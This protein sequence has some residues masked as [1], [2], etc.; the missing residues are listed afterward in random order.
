MLLD[1]SNCN[2]R[3]LEDSDLILEKLIEQN[4]DYTS[5][6][7]LDASHN[8]IRSL[9]G[10]SCFENLKI[11][12]ISYNLLKSLDGDFIPSSTEKIIA[13]HNDLTDI[14]FKGVKKF[15]GGSEG[16]EVQ[17]DS[18]HGGKM[19]QEGKPKCGVQPTRVSYPEEKGEDSS[20]SSSYNDTYRNNVLNEKVFY[21]NKDLPLNRLAFLDVSFNK[22]KK[23]T[24]FERY[25]H[26]INKKNEQGNLEGGYSDEG[27][28]KDFI[29]NKTE[30]DVMLLFFN[31]LDT[32]Y[33][34]GNK[35]TNLKGLSV[36]KNLKVLDLRSNLINHPVQLFYLLDNENWLKQYNEKAMRTEDAFSSCS[37]P[38][39]SSS[40][41]G[42]YS[43]F[44]SVLQKYK[45]LKCVQNVFLR[46]NRRVLKPK[47]L[48]LSVCDVLRC[49]N[50][51]GRFTTDVS[52]EGENE[53]EQQGGG[54]NA[55]AEGEDDLVGDILSAASQVE[56]SQVEDSQVGDSQ[57]E[58]SQVEDSQV[59][60][61]QVEDSQ[62]EET[63]SEG[64]Y[65]DEGYLSGDRAGGGDSHETASDGADSDE[66]YSEESLIGG[67]RLGMSLSDKGKE[68]GGQVQK[69]IKTVE[70]SLDESLTSN[71]TRGERNARE[72]VSESN[73][74]VKRTVLPHGACELQET[75]AYRYLREEERDDEDEDEA[76]W[77]E[78]RNDSAPSEDVREHYAPSEEHIEKLIHNL[79]RCVSTNASQV[80]PPTSGRTKDEV[81][82]RRFCEKE[83]PYMMEEKCE[84]KEINEVGKGQGVKALSTEGECGSTYEGMV[85]QQGLGDTS[86]EEVEED[87]SEVEGN[88]TSSSFSSVVNTN[89]AKN[90][91]KEILISSNGL[92]RYSSYDSSSMGSDVFEGD[93]DEESTRGDNKKGEVTQ[94]QNKQGNN[95]SG[96]G[97]SANQI[98][99]A[100]NKGRHTDEALTAPIK[101]EHKR[102]VSNGGVTPNAPFYN[103]PV[104]RRG[105]QVD[106][107]RGADEAN[108]EK[109]KGLIKKRTLDDEVHVENVKTAAAGRD[110]KKECL[111]GSR[112]S[113]SGGKFALV[114]KVV[115]G[116]R[117]NVENPPREKST[118]KREDGKHCAGAQSGA[119]KGGG[120]TSKE[121]ARNETKLRDGEVHNS[122]MHDREMHNSETQ[123][124][125]KKKKN[126][127]ME[128][129]KLD[130]GK[131]DKGKRRGRGDKSNDSCV[132]KSQDKKCGYSASLK[133]ESTDVTE[134][135]SHKRVLKGEEKLLMNSPYGNDFEELNRSRGI[136]VYAYPIRIQEGT[137]VRGELAEGNGDG[138]HNKES[139]HE[140][141]NK[142]E[143]RYQDEG[144]APSSIAEILQK[145]SDLQASSEK[146]ATLNNS[147]AMHLKEVCLTLGKEKQQSDILLS[148]NEKLQTEIKRLKESKKKLK[149]KMKKLE[150]CYK[151]KCTVVKRYQNMRHKF[152]LAEQDQV[153]IPD[154]D[155]DH[156]N[157]YIE[158][159]MEQLYN[160]FS[161][162]FGENHVMTKRIE[163]LANVYIKKE[164]S[165]E[166]QM[167]TQRKQL[168]LLK[169]VEDIV[170]KK[171]EYYYELQKKNEIIT[172]LNSNLAKITQSVADMKNGVLESEK[173]MKDLT[174]QLAKKDA[175][176]KEFET[177]NSQMMDEKEKLFQ[178]ERAQLLELLN[179]KDDNVKNVKHYKEEIKCLE[180]KL[181][182]YLDRNVHKI[183]D[184]NYELMVDKLHDE[185]IKMHSLLTEKEKI[186]NEK[187]IQ[188]ENLESQ[189][190]SWADEAT[191]WVV[192]AD[193]HTTLITNHNILKKNYEELKYKYIMDMKY[194]QTNKNEK[195]K[196]LIR[197]YA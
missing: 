191:N 43:Y 89:Q 62:T 61:S 31:S 188:I 71:Q 125:K 197:K 127:L 8:S 9:K 180:D 116:R 88:E 76:D 194:V 84:R 186:I 108:D 65:L 17:R 4:A 138:S 69:L 130:L 126:A 157:K 99:V 109:A 78:V 19:R 135:D 192:V 73:S 40:S 152:K 178:K 22:I 14:C 45:N 146:D 159:A 2:L 166:I 155:M 90:A 37:P 38:L 33:L 103:D 34:R 81:K 107:T 154:D 92:E 77:D 5:V 173:K 163:S 58:A 18:Y 60:A 50:T 79:N 57:V 27:H 168:E 129:L 144:P 119:V 118:V 97:V 100:P 59:E 85:R 123:E 29:T 54:E 195:V 1:L 51:R 140:E 112:K 25:L 105:I 117:R 170:K 176:L 72:K 102:G 53:Q 56:D 113:Q 95:W 75:S 7:Y 82:E 21:T 111:N 13:H 151:Q 160:V 52:L 164:K 161:E 44:R 106:K 122:E 91:L 47:H 196:E 139:S 104:V 26:I 172:S 179:D 6:T 153:D 165:V 74:L 64:G 177:K 101:R 24:T 148:Q 49:A 12:N 87:Q 190:Q 86:C 20:P 32:L 184:K 175:L 28:I 158:N 110:T 55:L 128:L 30:Q 181:K 66:V 143:E 136:S 167:V 70:E 131:G 137:S 23:L 41:S 83:P 142:R 134:R 182:K 183:H 63:A 133:S 115:H 150:N 124:E 174:T 16:K 36:F 162:V 187:N 132:R 35:L 189:L 149:T 68:P 141:L 46:G 10:L 93:S 98:R 156:Q 39:L 42:C 120:N 145:L 121:G 96:K 185:Q 171:N 94:E 193:K 169:N 114:N 67:D 11:L 48:F 3:S 147:L 80:V 15:S